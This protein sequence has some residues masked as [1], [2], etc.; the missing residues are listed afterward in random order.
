MFQNQST[1]ENYQIAKD[2]V[3]RMQQASVSMIQRRLRI[4]YITAA[5]IMDR[6]EE[7]GVVTPYEGNTPRKVLIK[8]HKS[9]SIN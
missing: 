6:L 3:I 4:G 7:E 5:R 9:N 8:K 2:H 1:E